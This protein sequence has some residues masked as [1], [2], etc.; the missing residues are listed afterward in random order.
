MTTGRINQVTIVKRKERRYVVFFSPPSH[1]F[2]QLRRNF[3]QEG[4]EKKNPPNIP[5][6]FTIKMEMIFF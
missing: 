6:F 3:R 1:L 5:P 2:L 4:E